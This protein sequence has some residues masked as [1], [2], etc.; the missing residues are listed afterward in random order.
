METQQDRAAI[1]VF[2]WQGGIHI[3]PQTDEQRILLVGLLD[4][5]QGVRVHHEVHA[6]PVLVVETLHEQAVIPVHKR[7]DVVP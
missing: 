7:P 1:R 3:E 4:A 2:W 5:L 6:G